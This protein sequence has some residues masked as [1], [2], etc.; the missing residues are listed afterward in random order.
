MF[1]PAE[2]GLPHRHSSKAAE[3]NQTHMTI[4]KNFSPAE[5]GS[6]CTLDFIQFNFLC[7]SFQYICKEEEKCSKCTAPAT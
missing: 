1:T 7:S 6:T 5:A 2:H 4:S 3:A